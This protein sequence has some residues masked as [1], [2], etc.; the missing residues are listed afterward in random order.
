MKTVNVSHLLEDIEFESQE[1][2]LA[3]MS[4]VALAKDGIMA[5]AVPVFSEEQAGAAMELGTENLASIGIDLNSNA[6]ES[7]SGPLPESDQ[8][9]GGVNVSAVKL[10]LHNKAQKASFEAAMHLLER[11]YEFIPV[12]VF[13]QQEATKAAELARVNLANQGLDPK[14]LPDL[15]VKTVH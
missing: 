13:D 12:P 3:F 9:Q 10:E 1:H 15:N 7:E 8:S 5:I 6:P 2:F 14:K 4:A 11:G